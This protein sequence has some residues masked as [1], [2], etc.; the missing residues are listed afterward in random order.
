MSSSNRESTDLA[1]DGAGDPRGRQDME[2]EM[3]AT[4]MRRG[5]SEALLPNTLWVK[6]SIVPLDSQRQEAQC[7]PTGPGR[8]LPIAGALWVKRV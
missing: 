1:E 5:G 2:T 3:S 6:I 8:S 7:Q 4:G